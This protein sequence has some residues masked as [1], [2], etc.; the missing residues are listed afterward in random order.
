MSEVLCDKKIPPKVKGKIY[1]MVVQPAKLY[2]METVP[3]TSNHVKKV[4]VAEMKMCRWAYGFTRMD[5]VRN[6]DVLDE[7]EVEAISVRCQKSRFRWCG[8][9]KR[10]EQ[11]NVCRCTLEAM[12]PTR[13]K[14]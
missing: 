9:I 14:G 4:Q 11:Q 10:R 7:V 3:V 5:H 13:R 8:H 2:A 12:P 1:K 6:E